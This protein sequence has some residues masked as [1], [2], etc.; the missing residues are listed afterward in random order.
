[1]AG[2]RDESLYEYPP[3]LAEMAGFEDPLDDELTEPERLRREVQVARLVQARLWAIDTGRQPFLTCHAPV[4][5]P[6]R[7][8]PPL[9]PAPHFC[10]TIESRDW[11]VVIPEWEC[12]CAGLD[13]CLGCQAAESRRWAAT[14]S[15][16]TRYYRP[17]W[18]PSLF[19]GRGA[20][21]SYL[22][23][24]DPFGETPPAESRMLF[25]FDEAVIDQAVSDRLWT[26]TGVGRN[27]AEAVAADRAIAGPYGIANTYTTTASP[28]VTADSLLA[29][30][31]ECEAKFPPP[32]PLP[33]P[34]RTKDGS[35]VVAQVEDWG[36]LGPPTV[37]VF[38]PDHLEAFVAE[39]AAHGLECRVVVGPAGGSGG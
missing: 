39:A 26:F 19:R 6:V 17:A 30:V 2:D 23:L 1:M 21:P 25:I 9:N 15:L 28:P 11:P 12:K 24:P 20:S 10:G 14:E 4:H 5:Y 3:T 34:I 7:F 22:M 13:E 27:F 35:R 33:F 8:E 36:G 29:L 16:A 31:R 18:G 37:R 38:D 32:P